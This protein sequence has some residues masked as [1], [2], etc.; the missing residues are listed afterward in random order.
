MTLN[1]AVKTILNGSGTKSVQ[2][3]AMRSLG[4]TPTATTLEKIRRALKTL[5]L[6]LGTVS[7]KKAAVALLGLPAAAGAETLR[8][9]L[10]G[11][12]MAAA[13]KRS[14]AVWKTLPANS[15]A[16]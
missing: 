16:G 5:L 2:S 9:I 6:G 13:R 1:Q 7:S 14:L 11:T 8:T 10:N 3:A 4:V 12:G 15:I